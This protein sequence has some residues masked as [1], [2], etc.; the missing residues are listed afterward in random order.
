VY[1]KDIELFFNCG[2]VLPMT[3]N[4]DVKKRKAGAKEAGMLPAVVYGPK[5]E[6]MPISVDAKAFYK[7]FEEAGESSIITLKGLD[8][9]IESLVHEVDFSPIKGGINHV[10]FYA[11]ERG[12]ELTT[13]VS[14]SFVGE[15]P[16]IDKDGVLN[17]ILHEV[18]ITCR[19]S[20]LP[21]E[22]EVDL[23]VLTELEEPIKI[24][25]L[26]LPEGVKVEND[27]EDLVAVV[28]PFVE[29]AEEEPEAVDMDAIEVEEKGKGEG[30]S[31][32]SK[33]EQAAE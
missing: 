32:D 29:Q 24:S 15:A 5:Q 18:E 14:L 25:D 7:V 30:A 19:P 4:L 9:D 17:K 3:I 2:I 12:K 26:K 22:I 16:A 27:P 20:D 28:N 8:E 6:A 10:D 23:S 13:N 21:R 33:E 31:E 1:A 11:I